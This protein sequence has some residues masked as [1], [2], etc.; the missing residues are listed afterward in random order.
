MALS[1]EQ[2]SFRATQTDRTATSS[3][4]STFECLKPD[5]TNSF[6][7][8]R[9]RSRSPLSPPNICIGVPPQQSLTFYQSILG[10]TDAALR[11]L[12]HPQPTRLFTGIKLSKSTSEFDPKSSHYRPK[13][14]TLSDIAPQIFTPGYAQ[15]VVERAPFVPSIAKSLAKFLIHECGPRPDKTYRAEQQGRSKI[16]EDRGVQ[17]EVKEMLRGHV[18]MTMISGL[19][20]LHSEKVRRLQP[21]EMPFAWRKGNRVEDVTMAVEE[22]ME[23]LDGA[24]MSCPPH[25]GHSEEHAGEQIGKGL[26]GEFVSDID[27]E[28]EEDLLLDEMEADWSYLEEGFKEGFLSGEDVDLNLLGGSREVAGGEVGGETDCADNVEEMLL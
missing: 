5:A 6:H 1:G 14:A 19:R 12:I 11:T 26:E 22:D 27:D 23:M 20:I 21:L 24:S 18:W 17:E 9:Q 2:P 10:L 25:P 16:E 3:S 28:F 15:A 4:V 13:P 7:L 8:V